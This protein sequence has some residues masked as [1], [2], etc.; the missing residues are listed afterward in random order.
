LPAHLGVVLPH[1][2]Q[3]NSISFFAFDLF[4]ATMCTNITKCA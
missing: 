2:V 3:R 1:S 4:S